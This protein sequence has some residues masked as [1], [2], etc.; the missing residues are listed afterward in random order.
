M[1]PIGVSLPYHQ[2]EAYLRTLGPYILDFAA[3]VL[4]YIA[5]ILNILPIGGQAIIQ[6][7]PSLQIDQI[8]PLLFSAV[9]FG[10]AFGL[11]SPLEDNLRQIALAPWQILRGRRHHTGVRLLTALFAA[12]LPLGLLHLPIG[13][14]V[15]AI[16][17]HIRWSETIVNAL[18]SFWPYKFASA[19][20][21]GITLCVFGL[22]LL[23]A[24]GATLTVRRMEHFTGRNILSIA[25]LGF[26]GFLPGIDTAMLMILL[27]RLW[28]FE[29]EESIKF[30]LLVVMGLSI[31]E[32][33]AGISRATIAFIDLASVIVPLTFFTGAA[34]VALGA[35]NALLSWSRTHTLAPLAVVNILTGGLLAFAG[36]LLPGLFS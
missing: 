26:F 10:L 1:Q 7:F 6:Q 12:L 8:P 25:A 16:D 4:T 5:G 13:H 22:L 28:S 19:K 34:V 23:L 36:W 21:A 2:S 33:F 11:V 32:G 9:Y 20:A 15:T 24:D 30:G 3:L 17:P 14:W 27:L 18:E 31:A 29:R 35:A